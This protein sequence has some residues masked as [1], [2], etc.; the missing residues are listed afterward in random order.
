MRKI[1]HITWR[2]AFAE[3]AS[4][5][6]KYRGSEGITWLVHRG[7]LAGF[8]AGVSAGMK[9]AMRKKNRT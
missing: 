4:L 3:A 7:W 8:R 1:Q 2:R 9:R 5:I 6:E